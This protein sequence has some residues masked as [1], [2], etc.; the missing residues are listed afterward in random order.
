MFI[1]VTNYDG[2]R[3][4]NSHMDNTPPQ[5]P[6][7]PSAGDQSVKPPSAG[8]QR[9][10]Q[11]LPSAYEPDVPS[12][13]PATAPV[14]VVAP[15]EQPAP[16]IPPTPAAFSAAAEAPTSPELRP[17]NY[18][19]AAA[20]GTAPNAQT[21]ITGSQLAIPKESTPKG[22]YVIA[23]FYLLSVVLSFA[24]SSGSA[25]Y[26]I[27]LV[28]DLLLALGLLAKIELA[29]IVAIVF[30][31][32]TVVISAL[33]LVGFVTVQNRYHTLN[34]KAN[35][36][37][38]SLENNRQLTYTQQQQL[39][40]YKATAAAQK[41]SLDKAYGLI[42]AQYVLAILGSAGVAFYLTRPGVRQVFN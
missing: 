27:D 15:T 13:P 25:Y 9:I 40:S 12:E 14:Q 4:T 6:V 31:L 20:P 42:Y 7:T 22:I 33:A 17:E 30:T 26:S 3:N 10:I 41:K 36:S 34:D 39:E 23:A 24:A 19:P 11:P 32:L 2:H 21:Y 8:G 29:R 18:Q 1:P 35:A 5:G 16:A 28:L 38:T 37:I